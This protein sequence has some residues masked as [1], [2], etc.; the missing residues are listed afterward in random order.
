M[1]NIKNQQKSQSKQ[2]NQNGK[3]T[4]IIQLVAIEETINKINNRQFMCICNNLIDKLNQSVKNDITIHTTK[5]KKVE[6]NHAIDIEI[7]TQ[8]DLKNISLLFSRMFVRRFKNYSGKDLPQDIQFFTAVWKDKHTKQLPH[9]NQ[10]QHQATNKPHQAKDIN[11]N[12]ANKNI[13]KVGW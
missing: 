2:N 9:T 5:Y 7:T 12:Q 11:S 8:L 13:I 4:R 10:E 6:N 3:K 1:N